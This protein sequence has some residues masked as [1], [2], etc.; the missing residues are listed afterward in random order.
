MFSNTEEHVITSL[1]RSLK[2][3]GLLASFLAFVAFGLPALAQEALQ[4]VDI[5]WDKTVIVSK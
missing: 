5:N 4:K 1:F 2:M 3:S